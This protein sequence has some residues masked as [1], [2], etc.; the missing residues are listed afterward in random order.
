MNRR[1]RAPRVSVVMPAYNAERYIEEAIQSVQ[2]QTMPDWELVVVDDCS[3][4]TTPELLRELSHQDERIVP[5]FNRM[6]RGAAG[7][8]NVALE[9][10]AGEYI[11]FLD[12]DDLWRPSKLDV[13][14]RLV[15]ATGADI[16]YS[17][18]AMFDERG[19][20]HYND[21]IVKEST[22]FDDMLR[23]NEIGCLTALMRRELAQ[24]YRFSEDIY[25]EDYALW[26]ALLRDGCK[27]VG[28]A[29]VLADYRI[30]AGSRS[31]N[32]FAS[33]KNRWRVYRDFLHLPLRRSAVA[34][35][36]YAVNGIIK[37]R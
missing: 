10:C 11:A 37:Y 20:R 15:Q 6:N 33:A 3:T 27:A 21:F 19:K 17:S 1:N 4:D 26:L 24:Q 7:S 28:I 13:Q 22:S 34:M 16:V 29:E 32:K 25:Q 2:V 23:R 5:V 8:R 12:S 18:Y 9:I 31:F 30:R 14:L 35:V 36:G